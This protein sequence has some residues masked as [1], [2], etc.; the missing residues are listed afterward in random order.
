MG[1]YFTTEGTESHRDN[2]IKKR[3]QKNSVRLC[4]LCGEK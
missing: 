3:R 1:I 2:T 4:A